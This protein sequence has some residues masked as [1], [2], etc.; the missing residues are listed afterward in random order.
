[1][2][3]PMKRNHKQINPIGSIKLMDDKGTIEGYLNNFDVVDYASDMTLKGAFKN[4]LDKI[5]DSGIKLPMLWNHKADEPIGAWDELYE[6]NKGLYGKGRINLEVERGKEIYSLMKMG[7]I[8]GF[9][10]GYWE[11]DAEY[12]RNKNINYLKELELFETSV[13]TFPCNPE[14]RVESV[15]SDEVNAMFEELELASKD[16]TFMVRKEALNKEPQTTIEQDGL[17]TV[18]DY[19]HFLKDM[20]Y[21]NSESKAIASLTELPTKEQYEAKKAKRQRDRKLEEF[22]SLAQELGLELPD[23]NKNNEPDKDG[24]DD[25]FSTK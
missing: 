6:D 9:S 7:A 8:S 3:Q 2:S 20:G 14:S 16:H 21:S 15:K 18:R 25:F 22:K 17:P 13:V 11:L 5:K 19:E 10:I 23:P 12:D 24:F 1:M 4:T